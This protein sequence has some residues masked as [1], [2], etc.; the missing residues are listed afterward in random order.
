M[1]RMKVAMVRLVRNDDGQDLIEYGLLS[2]FIAVALVISVR[3]L[4]NTINT[5]LWEYIAQTF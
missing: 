3:S 2:I 4:G 5:V 1:E